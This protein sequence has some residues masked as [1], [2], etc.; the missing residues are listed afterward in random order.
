MKAD[1]CLLKGIVCAKA[2]SGGDLTATTFDFFRQLLSKSIDNN[3]DLDAV[4]WGLYGA[5]QGESELV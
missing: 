4:F 3:T 1:G 2:M 5:M